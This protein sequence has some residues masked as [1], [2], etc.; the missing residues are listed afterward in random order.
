M[1]VSKL[2]RKALWLVGM[3]VSGAAVEVAV[4]SRV[5]KSK[6]QQQSFSLVKHCVALGFLPRSVRMLGTKRTGDACSILGWLLDYPGRL[7]YALESPPIASS[8]CENPFG[9]APTLTVDLRQSNQSC[10]LDC[11]ERNSVKI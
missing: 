3:Y 1:E 2:L 10:R 7:V 5:L 11:G 8:T 9:G 4:I 6:G